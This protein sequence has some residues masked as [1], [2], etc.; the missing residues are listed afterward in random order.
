M[1]ARTQFT[2]YESFFR[3]ISRIRKAA[4]RAA[5][6][7]AICRYALYGEEP[8]F[9]RLPDSSAIAF[10]LVKPNL[11]SARRKSEGG[12]KCG[13][14]CEEE[15][16]DTGKIPIRNP[17]DTRKIDARCSED[18]D[19]IPARYQE[20]T[21][22]I[23][24]RYL[25]DTDKI[26]TRYPQDAGNKNKKEN[27]KENKKKIEKENECYIPLYAPLSEKLRLVC[28]DWIRYKQERREPYKPMGLQ[29][30]ISQ[31]RRSAETHGD[32]AVIELIRASMA[33]G[34]KGIM[35]DRLKNPPVK[36]S[37][38]QTQNPFLELLEEEKD[39]EPDRDD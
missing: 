36:T 3:A 4:D 25:Q 39:N 16:E 8:D 12:K 27:K 26:P 21:R 38:F 29:N 18:T 30:L 23:P 7:D 10:E 14:K 17:Q 28:E 32:D 5:A 15:D 6:Y 19:K 22:K 33:S 34:Y 37:G 2:F 9:E 20:D 35:F 11:D 24:V 1:S 13:L 31:I